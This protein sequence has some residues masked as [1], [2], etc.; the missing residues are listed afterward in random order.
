MKLVSKPRP[1]LHD[2]DVLKTE[3]FLLCVFEKFRIELNVV[4]MIPVQTDP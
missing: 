4:T 2:S 3:E 1:S